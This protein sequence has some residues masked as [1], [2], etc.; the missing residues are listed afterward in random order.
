MIKEKLKKIGLTDGES[1][2]YSLL[3]E[4]GEC[5]AGAL[6]KKANLASSKVY[7]VLQRL[8]TKGLISHITKNGIKHYQA[9]PPER[10]SDILEEKK[11][12]ITK[13]Q[14]EIMKLIPIIK[15]RQDNETED[16]G[17]RMYIGNE[18]PKIAIKEL[19]EESKEEKYNYGYGTKDNPFKE[20]FPHALEE[21]FKAEK[22]YGFK[23]QIIFAKGNKQSQPMAQIRYLPPEF[24]TPVRTMIAGNKVFLVDFTKP[25]ST[26]IIE[27]KQIAQSYIDHFKFLW[28]MAKP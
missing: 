9:A 5:K 3:I 2:V 16:R 12:E 15:Q 10:L 26:I 20:L 18:G 7:E 19:I 8:I 25:F 11:S 17:V 21:F 6:I 14:E 23:T 27:N 1:E 22:K 4:L 28:K 13:A 24:V